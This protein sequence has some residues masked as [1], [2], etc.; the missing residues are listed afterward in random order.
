MAQQTVSTKRALLAAAPQT[1]A[2]KQVSKVV[3]DAHVPASW[4]KLGTFV[5]QGANPVQVATSVGEHA[6]KGTEVVERTAEVSG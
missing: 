3:G 4:P 5:R 6:G 2:K 1:V